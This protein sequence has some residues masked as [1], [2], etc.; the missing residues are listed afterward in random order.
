MGKEGKEEEERGTL[1][2]GHTLMFAVKKDL[3]HFFKRKV[4]I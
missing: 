1:R 3:N 4:Y 2:P